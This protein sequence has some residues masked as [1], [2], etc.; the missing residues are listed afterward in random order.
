MTLAEDHVREFTRACVR[1]GLLSREELQAE[2][3]QAVRAELPDRDDP[4]GQAAAW[5]GEAREELRVEQESWPEATDYE[6]LQTVFDELETGDVVVLQGCEDHWSAK[7]LLD[8]RAAA[9][10]PPRGVAWFT[11]ADVWHAVDEGMLEVNLWHGTT[12][13]A[14][15]G[16]SL[17]DDVLGVFEKHGLAAHFDEGRIEVD[18]HWHKRI[19]VR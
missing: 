4:A 5:I 13:N 18:A 12:A 6:R 3:E 11:P 17:L 9:G 2:V 1:A 16:D 14:A 19:A 15:P 7:A 10:D 8:E